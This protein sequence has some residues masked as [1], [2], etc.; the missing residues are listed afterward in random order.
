MA[1]PSDVG[2]AAFWLVAL[3]FAVGGGGWLAFR[4]LHVARL[5]EDTPTSRVRS[6]AQGYVELGGRCR[7]L[8]GS[9]NLAPLT[10]R[11]CVWWRYRIQR[12]QSTGSSKNRRTQWQTVHSGR[13]EQ[14]FVL[15]DETGQCLVHPTGAE[16]LTGESTTWYGDT[17]WPAKAPGSAGFRFGQGDY[18]YFEERIYEHEHAVVLGQFRTVTSSGQRDV[19][20]EVGAML[21]EWKQDQAALAERYDTDR[22]GRVSLEEWEHARA[23]ARDAVVRRNLERPTTPAVHVVGRPDGRQLFLIAA[24]DQQALARRYRRRAAV[25]FVGFAAATYALAWLLQGMFG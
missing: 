12:R 25:A 17:P 9:P 2:D 3:A 5:V 4:S 11:P 8:E 7:P 18:R 16:V 13:S 14:P 10:G 21:A 24:V 19:D 20:A 6:A 1:D 22:D 23:A 15:E